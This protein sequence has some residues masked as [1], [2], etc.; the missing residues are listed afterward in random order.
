MPTID[1][2]APAIAAADG[3]EFLVSQQGI[4]RKI[5]RAQ[6]LA[7]VATQVA[8]PAGTIL[9]RFSAG[10]GALETIAIGNNL[11]VSGGTISAAAS[12]YS[13]ARSPGG[14]VPS[15]GDLV[16]VGQAGQ[17]VSISY[18]AFLQGLSAVPTVDGSRLLVTP[19][20]Y[21]VSLRLSD[22]IAALLPKSGG[23]LTGPLLLAQDPGGPLHAATKQYTDSRLSRSG[24]TLTGPL[25]LASDPVAPLQAATKNYVDSQGSLSRLGFTMSGPITLA[26][27]PVLPLQAATRSYADQRVIRGGDTM[28]GP[29]TLAADPTAAP[30]AAT[31]GYVDAQVLTALPVSGGTVS[32]QLTLATDPAT[33][34]QA[35]TKRYA[36]TKL[37][38]AGDTMSGPLTLSADPTTLFHAATKNYVDNNLQAALQKSG[39]VMTGS[40]LLS[41]NP[42][43]PAQAA[44]KYYVDT[45]LATALPLTGGTISGPLTLNVNPASPGH[46]ANKQYVDGQLTGFVPLSGGSLTGAL[47]LG[48]SPTSPLQAA[49]KQYVDANPATNG[50]INVA[51]PPCGAKLDGHTDDTAAFKAAYQLAPAGGVIQVPNGITVL[52]PSASWGI[53][54]TKRVR[55][56]IDGTTLSDGTPLADAIPSGGSAAVALLPAIVTGNTASGA[57]VSQS[58]SQSSDFAISHS[59]YLVTHVGGAAQ[60]VISNTRSDTIIS[61]SPANH[62]WAGMDRLIWTGTQTPSQASPSRHVGRYVQTQRQTA[63]ADAAGR[64]LPQPMMWSAY[65]EYRDTTGKPSSWTNVS[66]AAETD[67]IGNGPDDAGQ[68]LIQSLVLGQHNTSGTPV[69]VSA[70]L[71]I[72]LAA[73]STGSVNRVLNIGVPFSTSVLDTTLAAQLPGAAAIR[74]ASGHL[75][76]LESTNTVNISYSTASN[77]IIARTGQTACAV[78][79]GIAVAVAATVSGSTTLAAAN[80]GS[81]VYLT[82]TGAYTV[83]LPPANSV[84][85]GTGFT[86][87]GLGG[88]LVTISPTTGD[89]IDVAPLTL[90][91]FDRCHLI[92]DGSSLWRELFRSNAVSPRFGGP[93]VLPSYSVATL[94][95]AP[96]AGAKAFAANGRKPN[97]A[98]NSGTGVEVF[99]DGAHWISVCSGLPVVN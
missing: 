50:V 20:G 94:P 29:L 59:S 17:N 42:T 38:R 99:F 97:E 69:E 77:T 40:L 74:L 64:P 12:P 41:G 75:I 46:A 96:G 84:T 27:D 37:A 11:A 81:V 91:Q 8:L 63:G 78:G 10:T 9:G 34:L 55:W 6:V 73:G 48:F 72:S 70:A 83:T 18:S 98:A 68:R 33:G 3:D 24:D 47:V 44:T 26:G 88:V 58:A 4:A 49:T 32:G 54:L 13:I 85:A 61:Q 76:A 35:A 43:S 71:G 62:V 5:T 66:I 28:T 90:Y 51:L 79:R 16:P 93:P 52:Q 56:R 15:A 2:L 23:S 25:Q 7:G 60:T 57:T 45:G 95:A 65:T 67:W 22:L 87:S 82:G 39:G 53:P 80:A 86:F 30:Q 92:S 36:D 31:K 89:S 21:T 14:V 19:A 1:Q